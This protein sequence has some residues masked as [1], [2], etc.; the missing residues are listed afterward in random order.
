MEP[1]TASPNAESTSSPFVP[2][3]VFVGKG[4]P[5]SPSL[6]VNP[7]GQSSLFVGFSDATFT[8][9][10][11]VSPPRSKKLRSWQEVN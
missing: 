11:V 6:S 1:I 8:E 10:T 3:H 4:L 7:W 5:S 2:S 9:I